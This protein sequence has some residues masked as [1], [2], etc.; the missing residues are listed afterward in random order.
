VISQ[1][2][3]S[4]ELLP[5][6]DSEGESCRIGRGKRPIPPGRDGGKGGPGT[7]DS[8]RAEAALTPVELVHALLQRVR[9][10]RV[11]NALDRDA[12]LALE[13]DEWRET[14]VDGEVLN[15]L[16]PRVE[17][18]QDDRALR[19]RKEESVAASKRKRDDESARTHGAASTLVA[20]LLG[21]GQAGLG[22]QE[23]EEGRVGVDLRAV[24]LN[25]CAVE[26]KGESRRRDGVE[27]ARRRWCRGHVCECVGGQ[28]E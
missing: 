14:R 6:R 18:L 8:G 3:V 19:V 15:L 27:R 21:P 7:H 9:V 26:P 24:K 22:A 10:V 16:R 20:P 1:G 12:V 4:T 25:L 17:R 11:A 2:V 13:A 28:L 23:G 5:Q